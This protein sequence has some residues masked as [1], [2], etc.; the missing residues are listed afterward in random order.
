MFYKA[1]VQNSI[2]IF[3]WGLFFLVENITTNILHVESSNR[4]RTLKIVIVRYE[5]ETHQVTR[6]IL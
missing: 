2:I 1:Q 3:V 6:R 5:F 4:K